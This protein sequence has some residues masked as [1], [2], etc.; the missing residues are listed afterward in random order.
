MKKFNPELLVYITSTMGMISGTFSSLPGVNTVANMPTASRNMLRDRLTT[1]HQRCKEAGLPYSEKHAAR[2]MSLASNPTAQTNQIHI[3]WGCLMDL[4]ND[5]L[6]SSLFFAIDPDQKHYIEDSDLFGNA[7]AKRFPAAT[8]DT[9]A[10]G[11]CLALDEWTACVFHLMRVLEI[12]L[13][14]LAK[15]VG[16]PESAMELENW[17]TVIDQIEK[18]IWNLAQTPK[19]T[20]KSETLQ[21]YSEAASG[22]RYF[23]DAWRN[24]VSHSR[25][26]YDERE[27]LIIFNSV[28][29]FMQVLANKT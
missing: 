19:S 4:I 3:E 16:L 13:H 21:F 28:Q 29:A 20:T 25:A 17:K 7:V 23:K 6:T 15:Q 18:Q 14:D 9:S 11:R 27:A 12:G 22:F 26:S 8:K 24:H 5:E 1:L 10:A 2:I